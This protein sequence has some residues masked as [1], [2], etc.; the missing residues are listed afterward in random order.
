MLQRTCL[1]TEDSPHTAARTRKI[2]ERSTESHSRKRCAR[3]FRQFLDFFQFSLATAL[4]FV[5][6]F[7]RAQNCAP[8]AMAGMGSRSAPWLTEERP[9]ESEKTSLAVFP[10]DRRNFR[11][12]H[13]LGGFKFHLFSIGTESRTNGPRTHKQNQ[14]CTNKINAQPKFPNF[15]T[16]DIM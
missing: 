13:F 1:P 6:F 9:P 10:W 7:P 5:F 15:R 3:I 16:Q 2:Q 11:N 4:I 14:Q 8:A 12:K